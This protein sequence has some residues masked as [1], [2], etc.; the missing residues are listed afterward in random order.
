MA[1]MGAAA[2]RDLEGGDGLDVR[3]ITLGTISSVK[4][5]GMDDPP[6][7]QTQAKS[8]HAPQS[9]AKEEKAFFRAVRESPRGGVR[10][11]WPF[12]CYS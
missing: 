6:L 2:G 10:P 9:G 5:P 7:L 12:R 4:K 11:T 3:G 1:G 8:L